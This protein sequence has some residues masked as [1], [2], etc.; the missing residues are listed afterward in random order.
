MPYT[1]RR[2]S[3]EEVTKLKTMAQ[4]HPTAAIAAQLREWW[5]RGP[6]T[7]AWPSN[8]D[9]SHKPWRGDDIT[10]LRARS[11]HGQDGRGRPPC[12]SQPY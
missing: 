1:V 8:T 9:S 12:S 5:L 4:E 2:W 7:Q 6:T 10:V 11:V 3:D